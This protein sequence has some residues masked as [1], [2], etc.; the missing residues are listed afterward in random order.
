MDIRKSEVYK[1]LYKACIS[2][3]KAGYST[4]Y[5]KDFLRVYEDEENY[6]ACLGIKDALR[7]F[8][9]KDKDNV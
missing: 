2:D 5:V 9:L 4:N 1:K 7:D 3:L 6:E 8:N